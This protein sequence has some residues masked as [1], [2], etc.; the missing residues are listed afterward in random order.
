VRQNLDLL[1]DHFHRPEV[2]GTRLLSR[3]GVNS[4]VTL[5]SAGSIAE[6]DDWCEK[7]NVFY[8]CRS[9]VKVG[10]AAETWEYL[11]GNRVLDLKSIGQRYA[12][13]NFTSATPQGQCG[14]YRYGITI[15]NNGEIY[16][17]PDARID[18]GFGRIGNFKNTSLRELISRRTTKHSLN[19]NSG[20]CYVKAALNPEDALYDVTSG[21]AKYAQEGVTSN[22]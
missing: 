17:C 11:V 2:D 16:M 20:F 4:V 21:A 7:H 14:I 9:P 3:L 13:R 15:E 19:S 10:E 8:T 1:I 18:A 22:A 5:Q 12:E 6:L